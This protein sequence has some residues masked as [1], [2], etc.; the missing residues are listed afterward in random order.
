MP[1]PLGGGPQFPAPQQ[2][3]EGEALTLELLANPSTGERILDVVKL[4]GREIGSEV[5]RTAAT[6]ALGAQQ[7]I[8]NADLHV[9]RE[10][11]PQAVEAYRAAL[12]VQPNDPSVHNRLGICYQRMGNDA[13]ARREYERALELKPGYAEVWNNIG[14]LEQSRKRFKEAVRA[15]KKAIEIKPTLAISWKNLGAAYLAQG[16]VPKALEE[17]QEA[18]RLDPTI[19]ESQGPSIQAEGIDAV[20]QYLLITKL[21]AQNGQKDAAFVYLNKAKAAGFHDWAKVESDPAFKDL[22]KDPRYK[23][24]TE[25][26]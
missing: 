7:A 11:Y 20:I 24:L 16:N 13:L 2:L 4:S 5:M 23:E 22:L 10:R 14:S 17:Y 26:K 19:V 25:A 15:Y 1:A 6:R 8:R 3:G 21:L 9:V 18:F 12:E